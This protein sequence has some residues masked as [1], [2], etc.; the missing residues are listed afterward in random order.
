MTR[1]EKLAEASRAIQR[2]WDMSELALESGAHKLTL[3]ALRLTLDLI[4]TEKE[5]KPTGPNYSAHEERAWN[6]AWKKKHRR[7]S[8]VRDASLAPAPDFAAMADSNDGVKRLRRLAQDIV[9][10][11][12]HANSP[13]D[14]VEDVST[15]DVNAA[16]AVLRANW[17]KPAP[18]VVRDEEWWR[19][20]AE[21]FL[22]GIPL[23]QDEHGYA[24]AWLR[25]TF[26]QD[27]APAFDVDVEAL[28]RR[29]EHECDEGGF[30]R[31][32]RVRAVAREMLK[33]GA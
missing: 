16:L 4:E 5:E 27:P 20:K 7:E 14:D 1:A 18:A 28:V 8:S 6:E 24:A 26:G 29:C 33:G 19:D 22:T 17:P 10:A 25:A 15:V 21:D 30:V 12:A 9:I 2:A 31:V 32:E 23:G 11:I 13:S 3:T